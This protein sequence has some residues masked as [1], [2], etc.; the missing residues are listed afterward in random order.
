MK[1][2]TLTWR[3]FI[4]IVPVIIMT[5]VLIGMLSYKSAVQETGET[6]DAQMSNNANLMLSLLQDEIHEEVGGERRDVVP[7]VVDFSKDRMNVSRYL[8]DRSDFRDESSSHMFRIW[9]GKKLLMC[10]KN[11]LSSHSPQKKNGFST[12]LYNGAAWRILSMPVPKDGVIVEVG[13]KMSVRDELVHQIFLDLFIPLLMIMPLVSF[14]IWGCIRNGLDV[15]RSLIRRIQEKS[16][17]DLRQIEIDDVPSDL[18]PLVR[19]INRLLVILGQS[20]DAERQFADHAAHQL[21][22]P[23]AGIRLQLQLL[24]QTTDERERKTLV[25]DL[26]A[27]TD[28]ASRQVSQL[29]R[30][31]RMSHTEMRIQ[32]I[33]LYAICASVIAD[34]GEIVRSKNLT[35]SLD[36][37]E[38]ALVLAD[39]T[40]LRLMIENIFENALKYTPE[41]GRITMFISPH[42]AGYHLTV[43]DNGPGI[44]PQNRARALRRF[45]RLDSRDTEGSGLGLAIVAEII[46]KLGGEIALETPSAGKGLLVRLYLGSEISGL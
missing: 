30:A 38:S 24:G 17:E 12:V 42:K 40:L 26:L 31:A 27:S 41:G 45:C 21:R 19:S 15:V 39:E 14:L 25:Q 36:G 13:E 37:D 4:R 23:L 33:P 7:Y 18:D 43:E 32:K 16:P 29:L 28:R 9:H 2:H 20:L 8:A 46:K 5:I 34:M 22:T 1:R 35:V 44:A 11:A 10:S 6:Y 3:L